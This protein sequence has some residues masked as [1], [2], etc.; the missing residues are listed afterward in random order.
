MELKERFLS[1]ILSPIR[2]SLLPSWGTQ[3]LLESPRPNVCFSV[4]WAVPR[5]PRFL[6]LSSLSKMLLASSSL[7]KGGGSPQGRQRNQAIGSVPVMEGSSGCFSFKNL[8]KC[9]RHVDLGNPRI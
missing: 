6:I 4:K 7:K 1:C 8:P 2:K 5:L 3:N 9:L